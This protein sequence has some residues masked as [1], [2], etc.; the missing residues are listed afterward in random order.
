MSRTFT[1]TKT[2]TQ[3]K[4]ST[5]AGTTTSNK[6]RSTEGAN[7]NDSDLS[8]ETDSAVN[9]RLYLDCPYKDREECKSKG[10]KWDPEKRKWYVLHSESGPDVFKKWLTASP[11]G[12]EG[13]KTLASKR[14]RS[15]ISATS[16]SKGISTG[17]SSSSSRNRSAGLS[18]TLG[19]EGGA[20]VIDTAS[21]RE[22]RLKR[23]G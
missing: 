3:V 20:G 12:A 22:K 2:I 13:K 19:G 4:T 14:A 16:G 10:G 1:R 6:T 9:R 11:A 21:L 5:R 23:F 17:S 8:E 18:I 15:S 7:V